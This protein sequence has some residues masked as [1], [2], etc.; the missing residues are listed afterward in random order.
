MDS[1]QNSQIGAAIQ[2][3]VA[4]KTLDQAESQGEAMIGLLEDAARFASES[5]GRVSPAPA[6]T[7]AGRLLD[8]VA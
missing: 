2:I 8:V 3:A 6:S 7:E 1:V 4:R 5:R